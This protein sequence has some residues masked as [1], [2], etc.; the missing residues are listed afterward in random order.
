MS[1]LTAA[2]SSPS[3]VAAPI[4]D[5]SIANTTMVVS[6]YKR[7]FTAD[8]SPN[9]LQV[10]ETGD[11]VAS[12]FSPLEG[13]Y[14]Q[15]FNGSSSYTLGAN[16]ASAVQSFGST[17][18]YT[19]EGW[20]FVHSYATPNVIM[21][22]NP[23]EP[24]A[25]AP[26]Q[27]TWAIASSGTVV[28]PA[29]A[30]GNTVQFTGLTLPTCRWFHLALVSSNGGSTVTLYVNGTSVG[31]Q[32]DNTAFSA[33]DAGSRLTIGGD[34]LG[35]LRYFS[36][37]MS[38]LRFTSGQALY[39]GNFNAPL[40][41]AEA[42]TGTT[43]LVAQSFKLVNDGLNTLGSTVGIPAVVPSHPFLPRAATSGAAH[44]DGAAALSV[45]STSA[46][47]LGTA[48]FSIEFWYNPG[49]VASGTVFDMRSIG[50]SSQSKIRLYLSSTLRL[51]VADTDRI[52]GPAVVANQWYH[53][54]IARVANVTS[55][56]I[57]GISVG[58]FSD[59]VDY[60]AAGE[61]VVGVDGHTRNT[62]FFSGY[63]NSL[64]VV[65]GSAVYAE[66]FSVPL[67]RLG[68]A[69]GTSLLILQSDNPSTNS[70]VR[71]LSSRGSQLS[72]MGVNSVQGHWSPTGD[73]GY[74][75]LMGGG[76]SYITPSYTT[77]LDISGDFT[78]E[79]WFYFVNM[80]TTGFQNILG[81]GFVN[82]TVG[83]YVA[84]AAG[85]TWS[86]PYR[87][88]V[89]QTGA[90]DRITGSTE[91]VVR[92]WYHFAVVR[93]GSSIK[94]YVDGKQ[95]GVTWTFAT[96][97]AFN[98][99]R[100]PNVGENSNAYFSNVQY[101]K[102]VAKYLDNFTP[103]KVPLV[104]Q[105]GTSLLCAHSPQLRDGSASNHT[106]TATGTTTISRW[107]PFAELNPG[108]S[109]YFNN[110][111]A[112]KTA[113]RPVV[114]G[115]NNFTIEAW[116]YPTI[117]ISV[118]MVLARVIGSGAAA[119]WTFSISST[120]MAV[121]N[122][123]LSSTQSS[124]TIPLNTWTHVAFTRTGNSFQTW[125]NGALQQSTTTNGV[126]LDAALELQIG[127]DDANSN[128]LKGLYVSNLHIVNGTALYSAAFAP[129]PM[130][131][132]TRDTAFLLDG[133]S[134]PMVD[135]SRRVLINPVGLRVASEQR[136]NNLSSLNTAGAN[137]FTVPNLQLSAFTNAA[138]TVE[139]W[140]YFDGTPSGYLMDMSTTSDGT[141]A[142]PRWY[143]VNNAGTIT[144]RWSAG[145]ADQVT[146]AAITG[147]T[148]V[149]THWA[150]CRAA[151]V[152]R[153]FRNGVQTGNTYSL[154]AT[155]HTTANTVYFGASAAGGAGS[156]GNFLNG[157]LDDV[158]VTNGVG[159]YNT[160]FTPPARLTR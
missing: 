53:V 84:N 82:N 29:R 119:G 135:S 94:M 147:A 72:K 143:F 12:T 56:Y 83:I 74:S 132:I 52:I 17:G 79:G 155:N 16:S 97:T 15:L 144:L 37:L 65:K 103:S 42:V 105:T 88:K 139:C 98:S 1:G 130:P 133:A 58:T 115:T 121:L 30:R 11:V 66:P 3:L 59:T 63:V 110:S 76:A 35:S 46:L 80:P 50:A 104:R 39:T 95:E 14:S 7:P 112:I 47:G 22:V 26:S 9:L 19:L 140:T 60:G 108:G 43:L 78:Y 114:L 136:K 6:A 67:Q 153:M 4:V 149:W 106:M 31:T 38:S 141:Q 99:T 77:A 8:A 93:S 54:A 117:T 118:D 158:R 40:V 18:A 20:F 51:S 123:N 91:I 96:N 128:P 89:N 61:V 154:A 57:D 62:G 159:R 44:F 124:S 148:G 81:N 90:G 109:V 73:G 70:F 75:V 107:G 131:T 92:R 24:S 102:G 145:G 13:Y 125:F 122:Y 86:P 48:D 151:G 45:A 127:N 49:S 111:P 71:D 160:T 126:D 10:N 120:G 28:I 129:T 157:Y 55:L 116:I 32:T 87:L 137:Y 2:I 64:R 156:P 5:V 152:V 146:S 113:A 27:Q 85:N 23:L 68:A 100:R 21:S 25:A 41:P 36:G 142:S 150:I 134:A 33:A 101:I 34:S 138:F 69:P